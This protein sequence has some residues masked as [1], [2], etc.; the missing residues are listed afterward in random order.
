MRPKSRLSSEN[1]GMHFDS[2]VSFECRPVIHANYNIV[3]MPESALAESNITR[4]EEFNIQNKLSDN[5]ENLRESPRL[6]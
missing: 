6:S 3:E 4:K 1:E 2:M 5:D